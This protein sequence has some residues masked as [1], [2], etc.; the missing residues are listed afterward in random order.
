MSCI[1]E[2]RV[3]LSRHFVELVKMCEGT[4]NNGSLNGDITGRKRLANQNAH[5][6][7]ISSR[8]LCRHSS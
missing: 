5:M 6:T 1:K 2:Y 7:R 4:V 8:R 3:I